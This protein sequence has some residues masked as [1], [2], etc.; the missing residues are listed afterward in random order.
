MNNNRF[1][2]SLRVLNALPRERRRSHFAKALALAAACLI[3][4]ALALVGP[5][6]TNSA[7]A[8]TMGEYGGVMAQSAGAAASMPRVAAPDLGRQLNS[9]PNNPSAASR[10]EESRTYD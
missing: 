2:S 4:L 10:T 8:Q 9:G 5:G 3:A 1:E 7:G 6:F